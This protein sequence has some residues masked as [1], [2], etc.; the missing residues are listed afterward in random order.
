MTALLKPTDKW[1]TIKDLSMPISISE[2]V[3]V[4]H[5]DTR[6][7]H[8]ICSSNKPTIYIRKLLATWNIGATKE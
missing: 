8:I 1:I 3:K 5:C 7:F 2:E 4:L 6:D